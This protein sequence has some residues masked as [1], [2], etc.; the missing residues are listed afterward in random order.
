MTA[1]LSRSQSPTKISGQV[2]DQTTLFP[3]S[4]AAVT[5]Q[6]T[7]YSTTT[8]NEGFYS[9]ENLPTGDYVLTIR[10]LGYRLW[11]SELLFIT[12][13][14]QISLTVKLQPQP[15]KLPQLRVEG[16]RVQA[17]TKDL[18]SQSIVLEENQIQRLSPSNLAEV[19]NSLPGVYVQET[20]TKN[21]TRVSIR[22]SAGDQVL[23]LLNGVRINSAQTGEADLN[24]IPVSQVKRIEVVKG[25]QTARYGP[26]ALAGVIDIITKTAGFGQ[27]IKF[28]ARTQS[29]SFGTRNWELSGEKQFIPGLNLSASGTRSSTTGDFTYADSGKIF[30]RTNAGQNSDNF[31]VNANWQR[32]EKQTAS[33]TFFKYFATNELPGP[34]LQLNDSAFSKDNRLNLAFN[35]SHLF[36]SVLSLENKAGYQNWKQTFHIREPF[37]IPVRVDY[38]NKQWETES[39]LRLDYSVTK[40]SLGLSYLKSTLEGIDYQRPASSIGKVGKN[41]FSG[42]ISA[43]QFVEPKILDL[44]V[45]STAGRIDKTSS[46]EPEFSPQVGLLVSQGDQTNL[47]L[48]ANWGKSYHNPTLNALFWKEDAYA[49]GNPNLKPERATNF[50]AGIEIRLPLFGEFSAGQTYFHSYIRDLI[51][52][53]KSFDGK[54]T[55]LNVSK[56]LIEGYEQIVTWKVLKNLL[57]LEFNHTRSD[58]VNKTE[59]HTKYDNLIPFRPRHLYN[60]KCFLKSEKLDLFLQSRYASSRYLREQNTPDKKLPPHTIWDMGLKFKHS[61]RRLSFNLS[62]NVYNLTEE[63]YELIERYPMPGRQFRV[64]AQLEY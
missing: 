17:A 22:G 33:L 27:P 48:T 25:A 63:H 49:S 44:L 51:I 43:Q 61:L 16:D 31:F 21:S 15:I 47:R 9:F 1:S 38:A 6:G 29:G 20:G 14:R 59:V 30:T 41:T 56:S 24:A 12:E 57:E 23:I 40:L 13:D 45:L 26:D 34:L 50:D 3:V 35:S 8:D 54:Y 53:Q 11:S 5:I 42:L 62:V 18:T 37:Y 46:F 55:P 19:L 36:S 58:A 4:G 60:F 39:R 64:S 52:W 7:A 2:L 10:S 32:T 28:Q